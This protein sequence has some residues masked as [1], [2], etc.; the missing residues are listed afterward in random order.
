[1]IKINHAAAIQISE[2]YPISKRGPCPLKNFTTLQPEDRF[3]LSAGASSNSVARIQLSLRNLEGYGGRRR[4]RVFCDGLLSHPPLPFCGAFKP[5]S[6]EEPH[7]PRESRSGR[8]ARQ[9]WRLSGFLGYS[10][11]AVPIYAST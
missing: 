2:I 5:W 1:V 4:N 3:Y 6:V 8:K 10:N 9:Q 11:N 7:S